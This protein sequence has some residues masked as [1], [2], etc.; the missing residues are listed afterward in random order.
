MEKVGELLD[1]MELLPQIEQF[2]SLDDAEIR[3]LAVEIV[4]INTICAAGK[5]ISNAARH[6]ERYDTY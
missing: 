6:I 4:R 1:V 2:E 3:D 5:T